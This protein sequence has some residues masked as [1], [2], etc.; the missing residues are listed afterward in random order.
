MGIKCKCTYILN[1]E[2]Y[3]ETHQTARN[4][5][6]LEGF[7]L[8]NFP[9]SRSDPCG[10]LNGIQ[11][12]LIFLMQGS[13]LRCEHMVTQLHLTLTDARLHEGGTP[14]NVDTTNPMAFI[15]RVISDFIQWIK[16]QTHSYS[17]NMEK[18]HSYMF[19]TPEFI[20][21]R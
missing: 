4:H 1:G 9:R 5:H 20:T 2:E 10:I 14:M 18:H 15:N 7:R 11:G 8:L 16:D 19:N 3:H 17:Q 12:K 21:C 13:S 6:H